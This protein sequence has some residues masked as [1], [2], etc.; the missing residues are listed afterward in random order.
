MD[1]IGIAMLFG[2]WMAAER[3]IRTAGGDDDRV[4]EFVYMADAVL[5]RLAAEPAEG[6]HGI[7]I[8]SFLLAHCAITTS[9]AAS[10]TDDPCAVPLP[11]VDGY[12]I[13]AAAHGLLLDLARLMPALAPLIDDRHG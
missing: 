11:G 10:R 2:E 4:K 12:Q 7:A 8:K 6:F 13:E 9:A 1:D 5:R 3:R